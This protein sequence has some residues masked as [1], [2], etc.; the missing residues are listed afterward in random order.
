[1][2]DGAHRRGLVRTGIGDWRMVDDCA[3]IGIVDSTITIFINGIPANFW[4]FDTQRCTSAVFLV[5]GDD[6]DRH[7]GCQTVGNSKDEKFVSRPGDF[8]LFPADGYLYLGAAKPATFE[9]DCTARNCARGKDA[10]DADAAVG[11]GNADP[12]REWAGG[13]KET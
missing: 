11:F 1:M 8:G 7:A 13:K 9:D 6:H 5:I 3:H 10:F 4:S 2:H 12:P